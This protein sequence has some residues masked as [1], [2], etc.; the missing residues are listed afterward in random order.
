[1]TEYTVRRRTDGHS[2]WKGMTTLVLGSSRGKVTWTQ[3]KAHTEVASENSLSHNYHEVKVTTIKVKHSI[4]GHG[5]APNT[6]L[7]L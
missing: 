7:L 1:M 4:F 5:C 3:L 2:S 6:V